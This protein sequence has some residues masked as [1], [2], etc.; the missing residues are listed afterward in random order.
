VSI[1]NQTTS[2][3][4]FVTVSGTLNSYTTGGF[5]LTR[6]LTLL[7]EDV[8]SENLMCLTGTFLNINSEVIDLVLNR[9]YSNFTVSISQGTLALMSLNSAVF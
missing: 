5:P 1:S 9:I 6:N 7:I 2:I 3:S 4:G 8:I